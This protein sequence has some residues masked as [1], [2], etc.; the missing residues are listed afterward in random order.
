M[1]DTEEEYSFSAEF[2][3]V[4]I[5]KQKPAPDA[6]PDEMK[7]FAASY[8]PLGQVTVKHADDSKDSVA[9]SAVLDIHQS[10]GKEVWEAA[11]WYSVDGSEWVQASLPNCPGSATPMALQDT[12]T[13]TTRL[14]FM[15]SISVKQSMQFTLKFRGE[16]DQ[17][18]RWAGDEQGIGNGILITETP[19]LSSKIKDWDSNSGPETPD[20]D[21][22]NHIKGL[23]PEWDV[24]LIMSQ[25]RDTILWSLS[26]EVAAADGNNSTYRDTVLGLPWGKFL[27]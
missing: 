22:G 6:V 7:A 26:T 27:R 8:P 24:K 18:W 14:Y 9:F 17:D 10:R 20:E 1:T 12:P 19:P 2:Q 16:N 3:A 11:L 23:N 25:T 21:L 4:F 15:K 5:P 13:E